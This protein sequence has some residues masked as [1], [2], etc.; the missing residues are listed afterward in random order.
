MYILS[1]LGWVRGGRERLYLLVLLHQ[2][3]APIKRNFEICKQST[4][5]CPLGERGGGGGGNGSVGRGREG[6]GG[7]GGGGVIKAVRAM[8]I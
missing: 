1:G 4:M 7:G 5:I 3:I 6:G 2:V 8:P